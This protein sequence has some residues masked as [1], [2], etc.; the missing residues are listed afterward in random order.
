MLVLC[1]FPVGV[2]AGQ[3]LKYEQHF[4]DWRAAG[5]DIDV[6]CFM[7]DAM[8]R[9]VY[10]KGHFLKKALGV[11]R[12]QLR[13]MRDL[14]RIS[15]Y[16]VV[17]VFM[18]V[19]PFGT[20]FFERTTRRIA[21][22]LIFDIEDNVLVGQSFRI[23]HNPNALAQFIKGPWKARYLIETADHV[24]SAS[25]FLNKAYLTINKH[26]KCSYIPPSVD[27][28]RFIPSS[29]KSDNDT[30]TIGWTGTFSTRIYLDLLRDV[31][32]RLAKKH[33]FK[34]KVIGNF[35]YELDGVDL[36]VVRW[37]SERE[38]ED[39]QGI[40]IGVYPLSNDEWML[41]KAGLKAI[42][43]MAVGLPTVATNIGTTPMII[44]NEVNGLL[45][46]TDDEWFDALERLLNDPALRHRLGAA[47]RQSVVE[48]YST[49]V[50]AARYRRIL[51]DI[52]GNR[53]VVENG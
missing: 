35:D 19:T 52:A 41:G 20:S 3:R 27:T 18:W 40:D 6:S 32:Q 39:L 11:L 10:E 42:Q 36:E 26:R 14:T 47:A 48:N 45:V 16:D 33:R 53:Q 1:P 8:W 50:I 4:N 43:Y 31:F 46:E 22:K 2:A 9:I 38:V 29:R 23:S 30:V 34:L 44:T 7:D 25:P 24:V 21:N 49:K 13:R 17:Y 5:Y 51:D 12:G 28:D 15:H 37:T